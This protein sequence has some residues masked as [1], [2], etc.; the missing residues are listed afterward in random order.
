MKFQ[1][2]LEIIKKYSGDGTDYLLFNQHL[3]SHYTGKVFENADRYEIYLSEL[4]KEARKIIFGEDNTE[5]GRFCKLSSGGT[6]DKHF[7]YEK[8]EGNQ[9]DKFVIRDIAPKK[10]CAG[11]GREI[12]P[13]ARQEVSMGSVGSNKNHIYFCPNSPEC[14]GKYF[15]E[16]DQQRRNISGDNSP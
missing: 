1:E 5:D 8:G 7:S 13:N 14:H 4:K 15:R 3:G 11:C 12:D 10:K 6:N 16:K 9:P 2:F